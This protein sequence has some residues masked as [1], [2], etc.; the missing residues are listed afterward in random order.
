MTEVRTVTAEDF[1]RDVLDNANSHHDQNTVVTNWGTISISRLPYYDTIAR[2]R[3]YSPQFLQEVFQW[4]PKQNE[5]DGILCEVEPP[6]RIT[7]QHYRAPR[8]MKWRSESQSALTKKSRGISSLWNSAIKQI[9]PGEIGFIYIAYPEG[10]RATIADARTQHIL[11]A[12]EEAWHRWY[13]RIPVTVIHRIYPRALGHGN[14]DLIESTIPGVARGQEHWLTK[15]PW[16]I[17]TRQ[18]ET[19]ED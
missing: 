12:L 6:P 5:W 2:T 4:L 1:A 7:V 11:K 18:F 17:L 9:P 15:V 16:M 14:P 10:S 8:C 13:V 3:L 19:D